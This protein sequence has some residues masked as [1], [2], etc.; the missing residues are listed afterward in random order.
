MVIET[1]KY[2]NRLHFKYIFI[3]LVAV[4]VVNRETPHVLEDAV[5]TVVMSNSN[6]EDSDFPGFEPHLTVVVSGYSIDSDD[7][8]AMEDIE[9]H[10]E[11]GAN[12]GGPVGKCLVKEG[13]CYLSFAN[14]EGKRFLLY[15]TDKERYPIQ[16]VFYCF[17]VVLFYNGE[18]T[19]L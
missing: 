16:L 18:W 3:C 7:E 8:D 13:K 12:G 15:K 10:F 6:V 1:N 11:N 14:Q 5:L 9:M 4:R 2:N 17:K 19:K